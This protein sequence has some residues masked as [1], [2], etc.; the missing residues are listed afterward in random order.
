MSLRL[1]RRV[2]VTSCNAMMLALA[3][4]SLLTDWEPR[5]IFDRAVPAMLI[6]ALLV[7]TLLEW[8][9]RTWP[10]QWS[11]PGFGRFSALVR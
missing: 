5:S 8:L 3:T 9:G 4:F 6:S 2:W 1:F 7:G 11:T 10:P